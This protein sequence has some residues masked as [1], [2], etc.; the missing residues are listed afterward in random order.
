MKVHQLDAQ[1]ECD[2]KEIEQHGKAN[3]NADDAQ[4][5]KAEG[6][7]IKGDKAAAAA[8]SQGFIAAK[9]FAGVKPGYYFKKGA[10]GLG[11]YEDNL[12]SQPPPPAKEL[13]PP[14]T[15]AAAAAA[16]AADAAAAAAAASA[17][18]WSDH[19]RETHKAGLCYLKPVLELKRA[20][21]QR[22]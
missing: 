20:W 9:N 11:Y 4:L 15:P 3:V 22:I 12:N 10:K 17:W 14:A 2:A 7:N 16:A 1:R 18:A 6:G 21:S 8:A 19:V 13:T 5:R